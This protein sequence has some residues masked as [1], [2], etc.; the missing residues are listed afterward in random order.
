MYTI[1][2][3]H[4]EE[5]AI[6]KSAVKIFGRPSHSPE[7]AFRIPK[8]IM[9]NLTANEVLSILGYPM[10]VYGGARDVEDQGEFVLITTSA[11]CD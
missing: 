2:L 4:E 8:S 5:D 11:Y 10:E 6:R 3:T 9:R 7:Y 1:P